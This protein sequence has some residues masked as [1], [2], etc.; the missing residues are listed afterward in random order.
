[1]KFR[2]SDGVSYKAINAVV[3]VLFLTFVFV[4]ERLE[5]ETRGDILVWMICLFI[6]APILSY[7]ELSLRRER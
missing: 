5:S 7:I 6:A 2:V 1:M 4:G 3:F